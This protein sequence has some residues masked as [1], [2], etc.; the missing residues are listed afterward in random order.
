MET[1]ALTPRSPESSVLASLSDLATSDGFADATVFR[2]S[3]RPDFV[4]LTLATPLSVTLS[5]ALRSLSTTYVAV[6]SPLTSVPLDTASALMVCVDEEG[7]GDV[8]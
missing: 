4:T 5:S 1:S 6:P 3:T 2:P 8:G 7:G